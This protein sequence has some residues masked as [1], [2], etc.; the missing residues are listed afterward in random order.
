MSVFGGNDL[1][2]ETIIFEFVSSESDE[3]RKL[4]IC[5]VW[6]ECESR[7]DWSWKLSNLSQSCS[8]ISKTDITGESHGDVYKVSDKHVSRLSSN[9][10][11]TNTAADHS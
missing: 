1:F 2:R 8:L 6:R 10:N 4:Q 11:E 7:M 9:V 3:G 5:N